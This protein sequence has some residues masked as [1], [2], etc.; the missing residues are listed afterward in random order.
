MPAKE[1]RLLLRWSNKE[2]DFLVSFPRSQD[3]G[4]LFMA[5]Q[6]TSLYPDLDRKSD[7]LSE[8][9]R[10]GYDLK[11]LRFSIDKKSDDTGNY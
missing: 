9:E 11:T 10:R 1:G 6:H 3:G 8:L 5:L 7:L 2:N 4:L